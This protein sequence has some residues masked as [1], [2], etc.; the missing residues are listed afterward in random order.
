MQ[1]SLRVLC[2]WWKPAAHINILVFLLMHVAVN[3]FSISSIWI[4]KM[5]AILYSV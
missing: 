3:N 1:H 2:L 5:K 4:E